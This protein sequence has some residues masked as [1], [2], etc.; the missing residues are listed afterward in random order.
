MFAQLTTQ[1]PDRALLAEA[2]RVYAEAFEG[3][4]IGARTG[5]AAQ[6][7]LAAEIDQFCDR[8]TRYAE[9]RE[10]FRLATVHDDDGRVAATGL[11]VLA[12]PGDWWRDQVALV[13]GPDGERRFLGELCLEVVHIAVLPKRQRAGFGTRVHDVLIS[14]A[15]APTAVLTCHDQALPARRLY[16]GLG[17][18]SVGLMPAAGSAYPFHVMSRRLDG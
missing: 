18:V 9:D 15:P 4:A 6:D 11:A 7:A 14:D 13:L 16:E 8:V 12:A 3:P 1:A 5:A 17:W 10:G 2:G